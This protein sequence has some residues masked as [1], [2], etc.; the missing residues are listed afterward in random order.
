MSALPRSVRIHVFLRSFAVQGSWNYRT[1]IGTGFAYALLPGLRRIYASRPEA[2]RAAV[3]RHVTLFNSHPYFA[4]LALGAVLRLEADGEDPAVVDRFKTAVRGSLGMVG[5]RLVWAGWR[6][7]CVLLAL[8]VVLT[9]GRWL[10][11]LLCFLLIYNGG[12]LLLRIWSYRI[13][14]REGKA[15]ADRFRRLPVGPIHRLLSWAGAFLVGITLPLGIAAVTI[16]PTDEGRWTW[17]A[18]A[19]T[20]ALIGLRG[21]PT[22]RGAAA[23]ALLGFAVL[24]LA[25]GVAA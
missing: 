5:D 20:A 22:I 15:V 2:L 18:A 7:V 23:L 21:G 8:A 3:E 17:G 10:A 1:L 14:W 12:H 19:A 24:G 6:P 16:V 11:G 4:P 13:G 9:G 25:L